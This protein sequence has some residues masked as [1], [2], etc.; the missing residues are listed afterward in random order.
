MKLIL[1][2][3]WRMNL[4]FTPRFCRWVTIMWHDVPAELSS[5]KRYCYK[6]ENCFGELEF[7]DPVD[8]GDCCANGYK[9]AFGKQSGGMECSPCV[10][11]EYSTQSHPCLS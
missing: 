5:D 8:I 3:Q 9:G 10:Q 7:A 2:N 1:K 11:S 4:W 6:N